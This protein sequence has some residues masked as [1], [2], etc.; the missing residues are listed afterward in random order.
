MLLRLIAIGTLGWIVW[1]SALALPSKRAFWIGL[2][3]FPHNTMQHALDYN[4]VRLRQD[5]DLIAHHLDKGVPWAEALAG[6]PVSGELADGWAYRKAVAEN[7]I[8]L[9]SI[10]PIDISRSE[11]A[12]Y[13]SPDG[14]LPLPEPWMHSPATNPAASMAAGCYSLSSRC[15]LRTAL[16][17]EQILNNDTANSDQGI[18]IGAPLLSKA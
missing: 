10:T 9:T 6:Q 18:T 1:S 12:S 8:T 7:R 3:P 15:M 13:F 11:M 4:R 2:T 14:V 16:I 5:G 17:G